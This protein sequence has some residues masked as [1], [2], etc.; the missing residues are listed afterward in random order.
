MAKID[1]K[2]S[3]L[4]TTPSDYLCADGTLAVSHNIIN[5]DGEM[6]S[7]FPGTLCNT[8]PN[9]HTLLCVHTAGIGYKHIITK[10]GNAL[11]W[12]DYEDG[13]DYTDV[14][15]TKLGD[16]GT[17]EIG[18]GEGFVE[19]KTIGNFVVYLTKDNVYYYLWGEG[20]YDYMGNTLPD[21]P[22]LF[23]SLSVQKHYN[24]PMDR[25]K[26]QIYDHR[27][28]PNLTTTY[29][30]KDEGGIQLDLPGYEVN[31][32]YE[33]EQDDASNFF[34][35]V[36][37]KKTREEAE[38]GRFC[39]PFFVRYA[40]RLYN[41][42]VVKCSPLV[43]MMPSSKFG[44][45]AAFQFEKSGHTTYN[46][47]EYLCANNVFARAVGVS[48]SLRVQQK[49]E[50]GASLAE[51]RK[52]K[53][54][55]QSVD[56]FVSAPIYQY[57]QGGKVKRFVRGKDYESKLGENQGFFMGYDGLSGFDKQDI[58]IQK[59]ETAGLL[60]RYED[61]TW[62]PGLP[63]KK[64]T[65]EELLTIG[66]TCY[67]VASIEWDKFCT[68]DTG[69]L[70]A[71]TTFTRDIPLKLDG[72]ALTSLEAREALKDEYLSLNYNIPHSLYVYNNRLLMAGMRR[73][74]F[75]GFD[76][77]QHFSFP[78]SE[79][80]EVTSYF[81]TT[82]KKNTTYTIK[83]KACGYTLSTDYL[84]YFY[85]PDPDATRIDINLSNGKHI[86]LTLK[87]HETLSGAYWFDN[88]NS[89]IE[90]NGTKA[91]RTV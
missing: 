63:K 89:A 84:I 55:I 42:D 46:E 10:K 83:H 4:T 1:I 15:L 88:F 37:E 74:L 25:D 26:P 8:L 82:H 50:M 79:S 24:F 7:I 76:L 91:E 28:G 62:Y 71:S 86:S 58:K 39:N 90:E 6:R 36:I 66:S 57:D 20:K 5:K 80:R 61:R 35:G 21:L 45:Q 65:S 69:F 33:S 49:D 68:D 3:G 31:D 81:V 23:F 75:G 13:K 40:L 85:Y 34:L 19:V 17:Q 43:L 77:Q 67:K 70:E 72:G 29:L 16:D 48:A 9:Q 22:K 14:D 51:F 12:S 64:Y 59:Q 52:W 44:L 60:G 78:T 87:R 41:G 32:I 56:V 53:D 30:R 38:A 54:I 73:K 47:I 18:A 11:Y 2:L 27:Y